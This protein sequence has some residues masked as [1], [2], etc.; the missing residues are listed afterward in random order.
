M[1]TVNIKSSMAI[2]AISL[3]LIV[4]AA[5]SASAKPKTMVRNEIPNEYKWDLSDIYPNWE[6]WEE[7]MSRL[8]KMMDEYA[9]FQGTLSQGSDNLLKAFLLGDELG[10]L[11]YKVYRYPALSS[12]TDTRDNEIAAR[13]QQVQILNSKFNIATAWFNPEMLAIPWETMK[14]W[15]N[16]NKGLAP[17]RFGIENLYRLQAHVLDKDKEKLLSYYGQF[18]GT[19]GS[20]YQEMTVSDIDFKDVVLS[21]GDTVKATE[22]TTFATLR[23]NRN[24]ADRASIFKG[25]YEVH[26]SKINTYAAVYNGVLQRDWASAQVRNY[27]SCLEANLD[28]NKIPEEVYTNLIAAV[29]EGNGPMK[30]YMELRKKALGLESYHLYDGF[31]PL[32]EYNQAYDY[33]KITG[34]ITEA[35]KPLGS[36]YQEKMKRLFGGGWIDVFENEGKADGAFSASVY[37]V[38][39]YILLNYDETLEVVCTVAHEAGHAVHSTLSKDNQPFAT[40]DYTTFVAEVASTMNEN[41]LLDYMLKTSKD[42]MERVALLQQALDNISGTFY[43]QTFF[44]DFENQ[45]H[46]MVEQGQPITADVLRSLFGRLIKEYYG[47]GLEVEDLYF[48]YWTRIGHFFDTPYYVYKYATSYAASARIAEGIKSGDKEVQDETLDK[49]L[50]LLKSGGNDYPM[51]L[52]KKAG[53]DMANPETYKAVVNHFDNLVTRL[54]KELT[55]LGLI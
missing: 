38:H 5:L 22:T 10:K 32:V 31:A 37:G 24:Q 47:D 54:E 3:C 12:V 53:V 52:L 49:Y 27:K 25:L 1:K 9:S 26:Q 40:A 29:K 2:I 43:K 34:M 16:E 41:L 33:N 4:F 46:I 44:S 28:G 6:T 30:R 17:Y 20:I 14:S 15:L 19:P 36:D 7:E 55:A 35:V 39:P 23:T 45:A 50:T 13:F 48:S 21:S 18:D 8:Q 51:E 11:L 42:P